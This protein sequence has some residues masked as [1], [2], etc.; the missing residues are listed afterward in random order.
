MTCRVGVY[1]AMKRKVQTVLRM[2]L[3][4]LLLAA[5]TFGLSLVMLE[6]GLRMI[7]VATRH[8]RL[9]DL[10]NAD[11]PASD[12]DVPL[13]RIVRAVA[14]SNRVFTLKSGLDCLFLGRRLLTDDRG[15][16]VGLKAQREAA[17]DGMTIVGIG[18]STMFGWGVEYEETYLHRLRD[19]LETETGRIWQ[20]V[21]T[22][23]PGYNTVMEVETL[24]A[25]GLATEAD[26]V[27]LHYDRNDIELPNFLHAHDSAWTMRRFYLARWLSER[28]LGRTPRGM[29]S[30]DPG[31]E[32]GFESD[33]DRVPAAYRHLVGAGAV[34]A[35]L[36]RLHGLSQNHG[37]RVLV[38]T[39][40]R[41]PEFFSAALPPSFLSLEIQ[42]RWNAWALESGWCEQE[43][44]VRWHVA[45]DDSHPSAEAHDFIA[46]ELA[47]L[48]RQALAKPP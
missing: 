40:A 28:I 45:P 16:R 25:E 30:A 24:V 1:D 31:R 3:P 17:P 32:G 36:R 38:I 44:R 29:I 42:P 35:A 39:H 46:R 6:V 11:L 9:E 4:R 13:G 20:A 48:I 12:E 43:S 8:A 2:L 14:N 33:P 21:N 34:E 19:R 22:A 41:F 26:W 5:A 10:P 7:S 47:A 18:D 27:I 15:F 23:V 37:F